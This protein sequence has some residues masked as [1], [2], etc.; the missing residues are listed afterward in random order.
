MRINRRTALS[1]SVQIAGSAALA[2]LPILAKAQAWPSKPIS[3]INPYAPG[4]G[5]DPVARLMAL[6]LG[7]RLGQQMVV[8]NRTGAGGMI[9]ANAAAKAKNDGYTLLISTASE[10][11]IN[12]HLTANKSSFDS[13]KDLIPISMVV[14]LP[15]VLVAHPSAPYNN[16]KELIDY[17]K[18][19]PAKISY[20]SA[21]SGTIQH[22]AGE[23]FKSLSKTFMVHIPY[24][25]VAPATADVLAGTVPIAFAGFP[26]VIQQIKAGRLKALGV[27]SGARMPQAP[28]IPTIQETLLGFQLVQWFAMWAPAGTPADVMERL[29]KEVNAVLTDATVR[30]TL[31]GQ[32]AEPIPGTA[33][34]LGDFAATQ[35]EQYKRLIKTMGIKADA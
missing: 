22:L 4:G 10:I 26:T 12:Q 25:G 15:F 30:N 35:S 19:N 16:V 24:R 2:G 27:T 18:K 20:A 29:N 8:E 1:H 17:A 23:L 11:A 14:R 13:L 6:E 32:G 5:L 3:L 31:L 33:K 21:G 7:K 28:E 34:A 9:G